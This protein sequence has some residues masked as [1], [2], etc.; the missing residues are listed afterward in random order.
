MK[1]AHLLSASKTE[2]AMKC[3]YFARA[4]V[5]HEPRPSGE[6]AIRGTAVHL[7]M[8]NWHKGLPIPELDREGA[9]MWASLKG[10][11]EAS[12]EYNH[13]ELPLLYNADTDTA[14]RCEMG[15]GDRAYLGVTKM[16]VPMRLDLAR[17]WQDSEYIRVLELKTGS[18]GHTTPAPQNGQL[19]TQALAA[20]RFFGADRVYVGIIFPLMTKV[21]APEWHLLD[22]EAL[23]EHAGRLHRVLKMLPESQ[24][25]R[26]E[27]CWNHCP[28]GPSRMHRSTCPAW[29]QEEKRSA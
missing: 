19:R 1:P 13:V 28:I 4:D 15:E 9:G 11:L 5:E 17:E 18:R 8:E 12:P 10:W 7:A 14:T 29:A 21:H 22:A 25:V 24:P 6:K 16:T 3:S 23:D 26:G 2:L 27:H 20:A